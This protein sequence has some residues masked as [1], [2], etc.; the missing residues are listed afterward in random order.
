MAHTN[1]LNSAR[2]AAEAL[3]DT[4]DRATAFAEIAKASALTDIAVALEDIADDSRKKTAI[5]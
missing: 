4:F 1:D 2:K 3:E 5:L